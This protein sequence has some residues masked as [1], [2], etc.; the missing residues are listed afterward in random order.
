MLV[1]TG[2]GV[3]AL[4]SPAVHHEA[5]MRRALFGARGQARFQ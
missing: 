3:N 2:G 1:R 5:N 4:L